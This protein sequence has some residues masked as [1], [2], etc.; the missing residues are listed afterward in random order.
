MESIFKKLYSQNVNEHV[1]KKGNFNFLSWPFAVAQLR[2]ADPLATWEVIQMNIF[3]V[4]VT[5]PHTNN[6]CSSLMWISA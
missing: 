3:V 6:S 2:L 4:E 1:E 5:T